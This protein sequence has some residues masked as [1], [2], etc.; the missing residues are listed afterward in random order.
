MILSSLFLQRYDP[1]CNFYLAGYWEFVSPDLMRVRPHPRVNSIAWNLWHIAR[2]EDAGL[3]RFVTDGVQ[4]LDSAPWM[5]RLNLPWRHNGSGMSLA[6]VD[7][8]NE[9]INLAELQAYMLAVQERTR[10]ILS[11]LHEDELDAAPDEARLQQIMLTEG[12]AHSNAAGFVRNY[13]G[14]SR[15]KCL[16]T[17]GLTHSWQHAGEIDTLA[18]LL[19]VS[20]D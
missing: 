19:G 12:L 7:E 16:F 3:N 17:F 13:L 15:A 11:A 10:A 20:F 18:G 5:E 1:L 9:R 8:L 14:W 4:V 2:C 6:E